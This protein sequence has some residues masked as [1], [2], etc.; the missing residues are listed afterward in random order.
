MCAGRLQT[1]NP[2]IQPA[3]AFNLRILCNL[4]IDWP[5]SLDAKE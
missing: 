5:T 3:W 4:W 1:G 2:I